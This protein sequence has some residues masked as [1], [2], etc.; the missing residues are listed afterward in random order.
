MGLILKRFHRNS[1]VYLFTLYYYGVFFHIYDNCFCLELQVV[2][3]EE[4]EL[5]LI[6]KSKLYLQY[7]R[8][9]HEC[10]GRSGYRE[11]VQSGRKERKYSDEHFRISGFLDGWLESCLP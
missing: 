4:P 1:C 5:N 8:H 9:D 7:R 6:N 10:S 2:N 11:S 3:I